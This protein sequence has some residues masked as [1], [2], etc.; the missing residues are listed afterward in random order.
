M[1]DSD[2]T[3]IGGRGGDVERARRM[4]HAF[5]RL[6][7]GEEGWSALLRDPSTSALWEQTWT[8]SEEHGGGPLQLSRIGEQEAREKYGAAA[9]SQEKIGP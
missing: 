8:H 6:A 5:E 7:V 1:T 3:R 9:L 4:A 2:T